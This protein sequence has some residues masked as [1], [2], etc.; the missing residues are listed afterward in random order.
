[1]NM[2]TS[3]R[4]ELATVVRGKAEAIDTVLIA[5]LAGG[6]IL[7]EDIPGVGKTTLAKAFAR[8][9][10]VQF[11][12]VQFTP[13]LLPGDITGSVVL[14]TERGTFAFHRGPIFT[15]V[16]LADEINRA[17]PRTQ[18]ALLEGMSESQVT[19]E[20]ETHRL[21]APFIV[22]ATQNPSDFQGTFPLPEAQLDRFLVRVSLGYPARADELLL[23]MNRKTEDPLDALEPVCSLEELLGLQRAVREVD[24]AERVA[25]YLLS[26]THATRVHGEIRTG[27]SPRAALALFRAAQAAAH[28]AGRSYV[29][30][31]D[32][33]R[34]A[35]PV[36]AH[37]LVLRDDTAQATRG[38]ESLVREVMAQIEIPA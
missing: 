21:E 25:H 14:G 6:H 27:A 10:G 30:P 24:I 38:A 18:A 9:F 13:D 31:D 17:S 1:M 7:L 35:V 5:V 15:N 22:I 4:Q 8:V 11:A 32:V 23:L 20:G 2:L 28:L 34:M 12:R 26:L 16:L 36:L 33:Q 29:T 19:V 37:R 3:I